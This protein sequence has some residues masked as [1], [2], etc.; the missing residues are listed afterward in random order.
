MR[1]ASVDSSNIASIGYK[2]TEKLL[3][4]RFNNGSVYQYSDV[5][6]DIYEGLQSAES[7]GKFFHSKIRTGFSF[8]KV[9]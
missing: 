6:Q 2:K 1:R 9:S 7:K 4:I 3:E 8:K 5:P